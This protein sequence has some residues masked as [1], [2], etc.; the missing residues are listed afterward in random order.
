MAQ[1][2]LA[3]ALSAAGDVPPG[4]LSPE[5]DAFARYQ[6]ILDRKPFGEGAAA[7]GAA[8][9]PDAAQSAMAASLKL[10][11]LE[12]DEETGVVRAGL[13]D[14]AA[15]KNYFLTIGAEEDEVKLVDADFAGDRALIRKSGQ[16]VWLALGAGGGKG[17]EPAADAPPEIARRQRVRELMQA[18]T[19]AR[20]A[21]AQSIT[22]APPPPPPPRPQF[23]NNEEMQA[24]YRKINMDLIRAGGRKG[25]PLPIPLTP[26]EDDQLVK[27]GV[28]PDPDAPPPA[29]AQTP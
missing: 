4:S 8:G 25:P 28:L 22:N 18:R 6:A 21:S 24:Y 11:M 27:E 19:Q 9:I 10:V 1:L 7:A 14:Q 13:V 15:H 5:A 26:E 23:K 2:L 12:M 17:Q 29:E 16:E 20:L 3:G